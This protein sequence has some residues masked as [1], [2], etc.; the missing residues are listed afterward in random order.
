MYGLSGI[1]VREAMVNTERL[2][3]HLETARVQRGISV[4]RL[5]TEVGM[6]Q[7]TWHALRAGRSPNVGARVVIRAM[8][9]MGHTDITRYV[10]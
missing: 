2:M 1:P 5:L 8:L 10:R 3:E 9:W 4:R 6:N 7:S